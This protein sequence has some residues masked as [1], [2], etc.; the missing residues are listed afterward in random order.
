VR[1]YDDVHMML[2]DTM[3]R[4]QLMAGQVASLVGDQQVQRWLWCGSMGH[5]QEGTLLVMPQ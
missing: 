3:D 2:P 5:D 4:R 1:M